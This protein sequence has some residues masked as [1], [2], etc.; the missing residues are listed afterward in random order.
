MRAVAKRHEDCVRLLGGDEND[1]G[2][3]EGGDHEADDPED[4]LHDCGGSCSD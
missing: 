3:H 1:D 2:D 4:D